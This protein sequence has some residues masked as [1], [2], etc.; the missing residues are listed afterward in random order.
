VADAPDPR[1]VLTL[2]RADRAAAQSALATLST[3][4]Q[5]AIVCETPL[6]R[7]AEILELLPAPE[8]VVP[9]LPEAEL[10]FTLKAVGL[11]DAGWIL[12]HA[13]GEQLQA[14]VDLDAWRGESLDLRT[15]DDWL[16][17]LADASE[18]KWIEVCESIDPELLVRFVQERAEVVLKPSEQD[19]SPPDGAM[20][21]EGQ[22]FLVPRGDADDVETLMELLRILFQ[23]D[24]WRYFQLLQGAQHELPT[25]IEEW[26]RRWRSGRLE[27]LG[28][29]PREEALAIYARPRDEDRRLL[30][31]G[32]R[33]DVQEFHLPVWM[34]R[35][36][37]T[38]GARH[39]VFRAAAQLDDA[40][41]HSFLYAFLALA[42]QV[43]VAGR[44]PLGDA[45]SIPG[46]IEKAATLASAGLE[47]L[48]REHGVEPSEVLRRARLTGLFRIGAS[49][50]PFAK[51][52][53]ASDA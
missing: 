14:C 17:A 31:P 25:E 48:A 12:A 53:V 32:A 15:L 41:R 22:F 18:D 3:D 52:P 24:Y 42:N 40:E 19:W 45:D 34:P 37:M 16:A 50:D 38:R 26:A 13:T 28:F 30:E 39:A 11:G 5:V 33:L 35:L 20:T 9:K 8:Q 47:A 7:R 46:A 49:L 4:A 1:R 6:A 10:C 51:P 44:M 43:A 27:D 29:P 23:R 21:L 36:P 2:A